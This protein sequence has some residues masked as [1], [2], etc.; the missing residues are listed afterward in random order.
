M[1]I[2]IIIVYFIILFA[3][4]GG[5]MG[6]YNAKMKEFEN[7]IID[8]RNFRKELIHSILVQQYEQDKAVNEKI[9]ELN[10]R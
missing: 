4:A 6:Y 8:G 1:K 2:A 3:I 7:S 5:L 9:K 10:A